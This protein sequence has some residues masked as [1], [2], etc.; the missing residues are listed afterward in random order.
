MRKA[1]NCYGALIDCLFK[2]LKLQC[3]VRSTEQKPALNTHTFGAVTRVSGGGGGGGGG[4]GVPNVNNH[5][6]KIR[7]VH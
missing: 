5:L 3:V 4:R 2:W 6:N 7:E 1:S